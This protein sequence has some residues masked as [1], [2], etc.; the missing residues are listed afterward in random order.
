LSPTKSGAPGGATDY[1]GLL[2]ANFENGNQ[3][4]MRKPTRAK[5]D[6][7]GQEAGDPENKRLEELRHEVDALG[8]RVDAVLQG[9]DW[10]Q[11]K[12]YDLNLSLAALA[13]S[14]SER[15][16][17]EESTPIVAGTG[18][19]EYSKCVRRIRETVRHV[20]PRDATVVVVT[21]GDE[22]LLDLYG[23][24]A[25]HFPQ[26]SDGRY[27]WYYPPDGPSV[28]V[29]LETLRVR[30]AQYLLFPEPALWWL[31]R[32]IEFSSHLHRHYPVL[33]RDESCVIFALEEGFA[34]SDADSWQV[35]L[36][37]LIA[38]YADQI[39][40]DPS[41]LD[42]HTGVQ[43]KDAFSGHAVFVPPKD[44]RVLPYLDRSIDIVV[45][46]SPDRAALREARRVASYAVV[47]LDPPSE[48][49]DASL[50]DDERRP[51]VTVE[52]VDEPV[53]RTQMPSSSII[54]PTHNGVDHLRLC[55]ASLE[56]TLPEPFP[57]EVIVVDD[58]SDEDM[59]ALLEEW[60]ESI[61]HL[62]VVRNA[63][64][65][66]FVAS[67]NRG[68]RAAKGDILI[69]LNDDTMPQKGWLKALL[70]T[71]REHPHVGAV[72][73][74]L[75]YPDGRLQEAGNFVFSDGSAANFGRDDRVIEAPLYNHVREVDYC[76][77]ALL[78]T[79]RSLFSQIGGFDKRYEPGYYE[80]TD[81]CFEVRKHGHRV[82]YQ[83][84]SVVV[85]TEGGTGGTDLTS[86]TK[87]FQVV[88]QG[89]FA[90]KWKEALREQPK[91]P[92][93]LDLAASYGL[94]LVAPRR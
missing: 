64:N 22:G 74:K 41:I 13:H 73:G 55:L 84:E 86:G 65:R 48:G 12:L 59:R 35:R 67:C 75:I 5:G 43:L 19:P 62:K 11:A 46:A 34:A 42:W 72:G 70:R 39:G 27:L 37:E 76:S 3:G 68:A 61:P 66:G 14:R 94:T 44:E 23:R 24:R 21:K 87:R 18:D 85:H 83:P 71:F 20:L 25:W 17:D 8:R 89:K 93:Q 45:V 47:A 16:A 33:L 63:Q 54:I 2:S 81:Y 56:E 49:G 26:D 57:G 7:N 15:G 36:P 29:Q 1:N 78:A 69:F 32:Y 6:A 52:R 92:K 50:S 40:A 28:I 38:D 77:A 88:N 4:G 80:D 51:E 91:R 90:R 31:D 9:E 53:G 58:G 30:G 60:Q 79:P 10:I 82:Y